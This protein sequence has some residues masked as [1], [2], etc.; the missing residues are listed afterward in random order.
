MVPE[1]I[2]VL[3]CLV[4]LALARLRVRVLPWAETNRFV[5][6]SRY[7][8]MASAMSSRASRCAVVDDFGTGDYQTDNAAITGV[9]PGPRSQR[10]S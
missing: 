2:H 10:A 8:A 9:V 7:G 3:Q 4:M 1:P 6:S 5:A